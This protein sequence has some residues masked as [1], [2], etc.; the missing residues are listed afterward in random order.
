MMTSWL[1][2]MLTVIGVTGFLAF[3]KR[4]GP[5]PLLGLGAAS[6]IWVALYLLVA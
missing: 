6:W 4:G 3:K 5:L 2:L 1:M